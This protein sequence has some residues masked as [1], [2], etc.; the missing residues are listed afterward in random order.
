ML[1]AG[2][3]ALNT[4][5]LVY[6]VAAPAVSIGGCPVD[7]SRQLATNADASPTR[8]VS[9]LGYGADGSLTCIVNPAGAASI[10]QFH[11]GMPL[12]SAGRVILDDTEAIAFHLAGIPRTANGSIAAVV[13]S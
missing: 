8:Y 12:D 13:G 6:L 3:V 11:Q 7:A 5:R 4:G 10:A 2:M 9:G 1:T